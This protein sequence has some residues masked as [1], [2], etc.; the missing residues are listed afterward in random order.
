MTTPTPGPWEWDP[1]SFA[2]DAPESEFEV[3]TWAD[4]MIRMVAPRVRGSANARLIAAAP[5]LLAACQ[6]L[7]DAY[8]FVQSAGDDALND[9]V[10]RARAAIA[11]ALHV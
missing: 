8:D 2:V 9:A 4:G 10:L 6:D 7:S 5:D 11:K 1:Q 3:Y